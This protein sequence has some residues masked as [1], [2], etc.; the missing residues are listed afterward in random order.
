MTK[1]YNLTEGQTFQ[2]TITK[3][4]GKVLARAEYSEAV[5]VAFDDGERKS[6]HCNVLVTEVTH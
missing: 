3:R 5:Y 6:L 4:R 1:V 2:T